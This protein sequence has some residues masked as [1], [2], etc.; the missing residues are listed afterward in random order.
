MIFFDLHP[1]SKQ[2]TFNLVV[3]HQKSFH[4]FASCAIWLQIWFKLRFQCNLLN[5]S[6]DGKGLLS[7]YRPLEKYN[8]PRPSIW[9]CL[10]VFSSPNRDIWVI[11]LFVAIHDIG[12]IGSC[13]KLFLQ[14]E[15]DQNI[16]A[17]DVFAFGGMGISMNISAHKKG[18]HI[19]QFF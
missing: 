16:C 19:L 18:K 6:F 4:N 5:L 17:R 14:V 1:K 7:N 12:W 3:L 15:Y 8:S 9:L 11:I 2:G 13:F 10:K